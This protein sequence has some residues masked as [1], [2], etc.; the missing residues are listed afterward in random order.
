MLTLPRSPVIRLA[1]GLFA[2]L[3][4]IGLSLQHRTGFDLQD[5]EITLERQREQEQGRQKY[6]S[7]KEQ[8]H[9]QQQQQQQLQQQPQYAHQF[10]QPTQVSTTG[11]YQP[12]ALVA[13]NPQYQQGQE[14]LIFQPVA[15]SEQGTPMFSSSVTETATVMQ[16]PTMSSPNAASVI[17]SPTSASVMSSRDP[18]VLTAPKAPQ[19]IGG[20]DGMGGTY[21]PPPPPAVQNPQQYTDTTY[22][23]Q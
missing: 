1:L 10:V 12:Q 19:F 17:S 5:R 7:E 18:Q 9:Q 23:Y 11:Y 14:P 13:N 20:D 6:W 15:P 3:C 22:Y 2:V 16:T 21:A 4:L 8:Q